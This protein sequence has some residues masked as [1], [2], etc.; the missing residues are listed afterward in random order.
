MHVRR[1]HSDYLTNLLV[2][3]GRV[4]HGEFPPVVCDFSKDFLGLAPIH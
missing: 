4:T 3:E 1:G 2:D